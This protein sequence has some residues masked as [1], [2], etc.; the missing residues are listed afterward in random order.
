[1][2]SLSQHMLAMEA[3][4]TELQSLTLTGL[5]SSNIVIREYVT[6]KGLTNPTIQIAPYGQETIEPGTNRRDDIGYPCLVAI[7]AKGETT[8]PSHDQRLLW[9]EQI[10]TDLHNTKPGS[11]ANNYEFK[12]TPYNVCELGALLNSKTWVSS[13]L[14]RAF[15]RRPRT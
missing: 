4:Q 12:V 10:I 13:V 9:R 2:P 15:F 11:I 1:M 5:S 14:V 3:I 6:D 7:I 8:N